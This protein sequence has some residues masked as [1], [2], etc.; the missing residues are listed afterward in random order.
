MNGDI[1][2]KKLK[3]LPLQVASMVDDMD[4]G[5]MDPQ[6]LKSLYDFVPTREETE[7]LRLYLTNSNSRADALA[8][9][10]PCEQYMVAMMV[11]WTMNVT[12]RAA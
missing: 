5:E 6:E 11:R 12:M 10:T 9:L 4:C 1:I 8:N 2:L 3:L 7:G